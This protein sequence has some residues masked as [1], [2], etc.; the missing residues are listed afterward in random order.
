MTKISELLTTLKVQRANYDVVNGVKCGE[1]G[2]PLAI[3]VKTNGGTSHETYKIGHAIIADEGCYTLMCAP[4]GGEPRV[5][6]STSL[7]D[8]LQHRLD[9]LGD[10]DVRIIIV[11]D[12]N[13]IEE[14][15]KEKL[16]TPTLVK[17]T[18]NTICIE[19][20]ACEGVMPDPIPLIK[21]MYARVGRLLNLAAHLDSEQ[22]DE[23]LCGTK[24]V[25]GML[26]FQPFDGVALR[27]TD[28]N[29]V[30]WVCNGGFLVGEVDARSIFSVRTVPAD[31][32]TDAHRKV[33]HGFLN[34]F[35]VLDQRVQKAAV[36]VVAKKVV[37]QLETRYHVGD[38]EQRIDDAVECLKRLLT[39][40]YPQS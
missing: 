17:L 5:Y 19:C 9:V 8:S 4:A 14:D 7:T 33:L 29:V 28:R 10:C 22:R 21:G 35:D 6:T 37:S 11:E 34:D 26:P 40:E 15:G 2:K 31:R 20:E 32:L 25:V 12:G 27:Y 24:Y 13:I 38:S 23:V 30:V 1:D 39:L 18:D 16:F 3:I 36:P